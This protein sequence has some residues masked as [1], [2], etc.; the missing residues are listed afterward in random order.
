MFHWTNGIFNFLKHID[1][2]KECS[3]NSFSRK[4]FLSN[5]SQNTSN[6]FLFVFFLISL[7]I[8]MTNIPQ[9]LV[10]NISN[11]FSGLMEKGK[12]NFEN[13]VDPSLFK[14]LQH[15]QN[16][17]NMPGM[18]I[19]TGFFFGLFLTISFGVACVHSLN[20]F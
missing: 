14:M 20:I 16:G 18:T 10:K 3:K 7:N 1:V 4:Q 9:L 8:K 5:T 11:S 12:N 2:W 15:C 6:H 13:Y 17:K 19:L